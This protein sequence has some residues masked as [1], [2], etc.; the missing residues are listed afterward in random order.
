MSNINV[1][2]CYASKR[3]R[4]SK[5]WK[6]AKQQ[7]KTTSAQYLFNKQSFNLSGVHYNNLPKERHSGLGLP[8]RF[9]IASRIGSMSSSSLSQCSSPLY[10]FCRV[11]WVSVLRGLEL[12]VPLQGALAPRQV[13]R[14]AA[15][16]VDLRVGCLPTIK[17]APHGLDRRP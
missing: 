14:I 15:K 4:E 12:Q 5:S 11:P 17:R 6:K 7:N 9:L 2:I 16:A 3:R 13:G 1:S 8:V 10:L